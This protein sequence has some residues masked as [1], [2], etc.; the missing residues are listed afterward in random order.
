MVPKLEFGMIK[1]TYQGVE[2]PGRMTLDEVLVGDSEREYLD[3]GLLEIVF[4]RKENQPE[5]FEKY[6]SE[7]MTPLLNS[8]KRSPFQPV[9]YPKY[10]SL[11]NELVQI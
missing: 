4:S 3:R 1:L 2:I 6:Y 8:I 11:M 9:L 7:K 10:Y 5:E